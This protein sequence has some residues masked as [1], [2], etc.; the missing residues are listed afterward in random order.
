M[1]M[2]MMAMI[3]IIIIIVIC[4]YSLKQYNVTAMEL[5]LGD[6]ML[7]YSTVKGKR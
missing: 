3:I 7:M 1:I 6:H 5:D 4:S 2:I